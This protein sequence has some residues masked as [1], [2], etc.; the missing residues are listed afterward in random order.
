[1][2]TG[3]AEKHKYANHFSQLRAGLSRI[4]RWLRHAADPSNRSLKAAG[5]ERY[6]AVWSGGQVRYRSTAHVSCPPDL[7]DPHNLSA[8]GSVCS[9][10]EHQYPENVWSGVR[11]GNVCLGGT[12]Y[13]CLTVRAWPARWNFDSVLYNRSFFIFHSDS[14]EPFPS[15]PSL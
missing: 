13:Q 5:F 3:P 14:T 8:L 11:L 7:Q 10:S 4:I 15:A 9:T 1:V 2:R 12:P 6:E